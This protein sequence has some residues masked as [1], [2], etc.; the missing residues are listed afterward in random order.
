MDRGSYERLSIRDSAQSLKKYGSTSRHVTKPDTF[1]KHYV[2]NADTLQ[3]IALKYDV[4]IE[5]IRRANKLWTS[6][7]LFLKEHLLI[8]LDAASGAASDV[9]RLDRD[10]PSSV[11]T[12]DSIRS[13][14]FDEEDVDG[15]LG[16]IDAAIASTKEDVRKTTRNSEFATGLEHSDRRH[17]A[18]SRMKQLVNNNMS[19]SNE[20]DFSRGHDQEAVQGVATPVV[21]AAVLP[22]RGKKVRN[23][24]R[25]HE[26][27]Q[28]ELFEL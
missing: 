24:I 26:R 9:R 17:P 20:A 10:R 3:G 15:F 25:Q 16:K 8:P 14:S 27:Q 2:D 18:V 13:G 1:I 12:S 6:D 28:D 11:A 19:L 5:Q 22:Q 23:S 7:S 4:T 21:G